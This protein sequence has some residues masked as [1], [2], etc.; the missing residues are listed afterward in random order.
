M[1]KTKISV[2]H[3]A[4]GLSDLKLLMKK[5]NNYACYFWNVAMDF[6][7]GQLGCLF[8]WWSDGVS[9]LLKGIY[10]MFVHSSWFIDRWTSKMCSVFDMKLQNNKAHCVNATNSYKN[11]SA[12]TW[13]T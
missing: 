11:E 3:L 2:V 6:V 10:M 7:I 8:P 4:I 1:F 12:P 9:N 13:S 5:K